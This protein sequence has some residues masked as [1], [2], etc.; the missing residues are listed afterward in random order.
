MPDGS[1]RT[2]PGRAQPG[3]RDPLRIVHQVSTDVVAYEKRDE[4]Q[5]DGELERVGS[6]R[7]RTG[8]RYK[9]GRDSGGESAVS[10]RVT[11]EVTYRKGLPARERSQLQSDEREKG[12]TETDVANDDGNQSAAVLNESR[13]R[14][15]EIAE[16]DERAQRS[17]RKRAECPD[18]AKRRGERRDSISSRAGSGTLIRGRGEQTYLLTKQ[19]LI[20]AVI[21]RSLKRRHVSLAAGRYAFP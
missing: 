20:K 14:S 13:I 19:S 3:P 7:K 12:K 5:Q 15:F 6:P 18:A 8:K 4:L 11:D 16:R 17:D 2:A 10:E 1:T 9:R 21:P